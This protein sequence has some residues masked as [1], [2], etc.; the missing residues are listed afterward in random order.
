MTS[1]DLHLPPKEELVL[2]PN[3]LSLYRYDLRYLSL[4]P[5]QRVTANRLSEKMF[6]VVQ[7]NGLLERLTNSDK[8]GDVEYVASLTD[9][10]KDKL[11]KGEWVIGTRKET[12][13]LYGVLKNA[14]TGKIVHQVD[15]VP[16]EIEQL[17]PLTGLS[18]I[19]AQLGQIVRQLEDIAGVL[20]RVEQ[21]QYTDRYAGFFT[22]RQLVIEALV[23]RNDAVKQKLLISAIEQTNETRSR[24]ML[25]LQL[26][27]TSYTN[28]NLSNR[29]ST[30]LE[31]RIPQTIN[32]LNAL[33]QLTVITYTALEEM[34]AIIACLTNYKTFV[35][36]IFFTPY[37]N[38]GRCLAWQLDNF[39]KGNSSYFRNSFSDVTTNIE[40]VIE[41]ATQLSLEDRKL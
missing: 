16:S 14:H 19:Q 35:K 9:Y 29:D 8:K 30:I 22:A 5:L 11:A 3:E 12:G 28:P 23:S 31:Y 10:A 7:E 34:D 36:D 41:A 40:K 37:T 13:T 39:S 33:V 26:D 6:Q 17:A 15:L 27:V 25:A 32:Y 18:A 4:A 1:F 20:A 38:E 2:N 24:L 21:G